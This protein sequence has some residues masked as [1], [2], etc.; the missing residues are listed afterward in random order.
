MAFSTDFERLL[1]GLP[2]GWTQATVGLHVTQ[3]DPSADPIDIADALAQFG[4]YPGDREKSRF[5]ITTRPGDPV[6][7]PSTIS[8][9]LRRI[10][11]A[12]GGHP[13]GIKGFLTL[14]D[15]QTR[16]KHQLQQ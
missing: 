4:I 10:E 8:A 9:V 16:E 5:T 7:S 14:E 15:V 2:A 11:S 1:L 13:R 3:P 12:P 6:S